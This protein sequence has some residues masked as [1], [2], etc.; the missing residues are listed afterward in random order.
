MTLCRQ[1]LRGGGPISRI[2][3][4]RR[5]HN[6]V[7]GGVPE[8]GDRVAFEWKYVFQAARKS[9]I[10]SQSWASSP[11]IRTVWDSSGL[12]LMG[13]GQESDREGEVVS[14]EAALSAP[15]RGRD[16]VPKSTFCG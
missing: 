14:W 3:P 6:G 8:E 5:G 1:D 16:E 7:E 11:K 13:L 9:P 12:I 15:G 2:L 10:M 4:P